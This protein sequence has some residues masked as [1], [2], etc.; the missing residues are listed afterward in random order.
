MLISAKE[1]NR[2]HSFYVYQ[3]TICGKERPTVATFL[4]T[5]SNIAIN[6]EYLWVK[7]Y[8]SSD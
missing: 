5:L 4:L 1:T 3:L 8:M 7:K 2:V 6:L